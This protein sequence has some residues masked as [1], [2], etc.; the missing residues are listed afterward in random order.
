M[1]KKDP[2]HIKF[3]QR[4][5][6]LA[7]LGLGQT[8]PNP[9]VGSVLV[10]KGNIVSEGWHQKKG[11]AHAEVHAIQNLKDKS[12]LGMCTLYV[13]LEPCNHQGATPPCSDLIVSSRIPRVVVGCFDPFKLVNGAGIE[14]LK[15]AGCEVLIGVLEQ[16][17]QEIN[18][19]FFTFH[20]KKRPYIILKWAQSTDGF[21]A[22]L[23]QNRSL[24]EPVWLSNESS[25]TFS[26]LWRSQEQS[27]L[28]GVQTIID[29][30]PSL[31]TRKIQGSSPLR[32][33]LDPQGRIPKESNVLLDEFDTLIFSTKK[34]ATTKEVVISDFKK[35]LE[36]L[37]ALLHQRNIQ[38]LIVEGGSKTL[39]GFID[40]DLWDE[41][42]IFTSPKVLN[43]GI[44]KPVF[45][46]KQKSSNLIE[47]DMLEIILPNPEKER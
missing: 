33:V 26:H 37:C 13:N 14:K 5:L 23:K 4:C 6:D 11:E 9:L 7:K 39:Q 19:R 25:Q 18:K 21:I 27:I 30:N 15:N 3:M 42:R 31:T 8:Y 24:K 44:K 32:I 40:S 38:S 47:G 28:V 34:S 36:Q 35:I 29:D 16:E 17:A 2:I 1:N 43:E 45:D 22:P 12:I 41:A 46:G 20:L 10:Y